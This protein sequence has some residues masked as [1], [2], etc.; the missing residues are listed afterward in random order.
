MSIVNNT[1]NSERHEH[2]RDVETG[3]ASD[4][5][6]EKVAASV[7]GDDEPMEKQHPTAPGALVWFTYPFVLIFALLIGLAMLAYFNG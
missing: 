3:R 1:P 7:K 4:T 5:V 2:A 6:L